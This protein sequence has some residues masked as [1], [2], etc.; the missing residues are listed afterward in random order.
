MHGCPLSAHLT[1][2][3]I[4]ILRLA[5][6]KSDCW[7]V[8]RRTPQSRPTSRLCVT[9][10]MAIA[11]ELTIEEMEAICTRE[12]LA[13]QKVAFRLESNSSSFKVAA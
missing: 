7:N 13:P 12:R 8:N 4:Q 9:Y 6:D 10:P 3:T 1:Q 2:Q 11:A 5:R